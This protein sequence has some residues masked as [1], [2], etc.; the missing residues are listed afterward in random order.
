MGIPTGKCVVY[1]AAGAKPEWLLPVTVDVG[2]N[3]RQLQQDPLYIGLPQERLRGQEY[4][5]LMAE[6]V[7]GLQQRFG[8]PVLVHWEDLAG[9]NAFQILQ[10]SCRT[11]NFTL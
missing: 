11:T 1:G 4:V 10:V 8:R 5:D 3:N 6:L 9:R 7:V 2:T